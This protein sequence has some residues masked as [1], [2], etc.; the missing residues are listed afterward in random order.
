MITVYIYI[1][2]IIYRFN[3]KYNNYW[4]SLKYHKII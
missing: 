2:T 1:I 3:L 4:D